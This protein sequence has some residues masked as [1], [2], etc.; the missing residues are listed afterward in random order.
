MSLETSHELALQYLAMCFSSA[1]PLE[2]AQI[3][4]SRWTQAYNIEKSWFEEI[5]ASGET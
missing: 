4:D 2:R 5:E 3:A 1:Q